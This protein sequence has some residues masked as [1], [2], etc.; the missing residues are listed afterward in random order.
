MLKHEDYFKV[1]DTFTVKEMFLANVHLGHKD[2]SLND[3]MKP[4]I[5]GSRS[6]HVIFDLDITAY[7]LR[8]ALN[9]CAHIAYRDGIILFISQNKRSTLM[10]ERT[11]K[12]CKEFAYTRAW[13]NGIFTSS[14]SIFSCDVRLPDLCIM[15]NTKYETGQV[16]AAV[17]EAAKLC[18][19]V[20]GIVDSD[21]SPN[22][23]TYPVPGNDD[24]PSAISFYLKVF[25]TA[26]MRG[27]KK[28]KESEKELK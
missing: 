3:N 20:I 27:K 1:H 23:I 12:E 5:F 4:F 28:R 21:C 14:S 2:V 18:I 17:H 10:V 13:R 11:A 8:K 24:T 25:R 9:F 7:H 6:G 26:I 22:L 19:P 16:H 15:L